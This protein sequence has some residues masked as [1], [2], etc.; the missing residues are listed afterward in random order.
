MMKINKKKL[1]DIIK[2][3][4][5]RRILVLGDIMLDRYIW[6]TV[7]RISPEAPVPVV[8]VSKDTLCLGGAGN[9][10]NNLKSLGAFP[11]LLGTIGDD[12]EGKWI[13]KNLEYKKGLQIISNRATITKTRIIAH[14]QQVVRVDQEENHPVSPEINQKMLQFIKKE[15]YEGILI[16][17]YNKG[18][19][20]KLI[21]NELLFFAQKNKIPVFVDPKIDNISHFSP[22]TLLT[23]NHFEAAAMVNHSCDK[24]KEI[25]Q[26]GRKMFSRIQTKYLIIKRGQKGMT[27]FRKNH[28]PIHIPTIAKEVFDVTGAGDTV[29]ATSSLALLSGAS[30]EEA[31]FLANTAAGIVV[32]KIGTAV[33]TTEELAQLVK[34]S[35]RVEL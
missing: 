35:H 29:I 20:S 27:V 31:A 34:D 4:K 24:D 18:V 1:E 13:L 17:D 33:T 15:N 12:E 5:D 22:I 23:P 19:I 30:I 10:C 6:G 11:I 26:A 3:F 28:R 16:S 32:N 9:V 14:Q 2:N 25:E 21:M 8:H 7:D